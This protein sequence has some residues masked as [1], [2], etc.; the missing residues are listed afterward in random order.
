MANEV[1]VFICFDTVDA[2]LI[3]V[4]IY[5]ITLASFD[6][7]V[8]FVLQDYKKSITAGKCFGCNQGKMLW[9]NVPCKHA[10][11]CTGCK[12]HFIVAA[13]A[14]AH[15]CVVCD[16]EVRRMELISHPDY[17]LTI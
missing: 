15:L 10:L 14:F 7:I 11:W 4:C 5:L 17:A 6:I 2:K 13:G 16:M 12:V 9:A 3:S 8:I 1:I